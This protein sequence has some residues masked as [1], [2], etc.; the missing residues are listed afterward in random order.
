[1]IDRKDKIEMVLKPARF[2]GTDTQEAAQ[3]WLRLV[4]ELEFMTEPEARQPRFK[5][6]LNAI[7]IAA[8]NDQS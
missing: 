5:G 3:A 2:C 1:M 8:T 4:R 6:L 7:N